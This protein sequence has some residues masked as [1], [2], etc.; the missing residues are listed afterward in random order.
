MK[1]NELV[2]SARGHDRQESKI[3]DKSANPLYGAIAWAGISAGT[4]LMVLTLP[5]HESQSVY[6]D[7]NSEFSP[8][9]ERM[10]GDSPDKL[11]SQ[12]V[13]EED[14]AKFLARTK[15]NIVPQA[16][17]TT[18]EVQRPSESASSEIVSG[19]ATY[20][21]VDDGY[22][23]QNRLGCTHEP[24]DPDDPTTAAR[25]ETSPFVCGD[26]LEVCDVNSC[27]EVEIKDTC[28]GCDDYGIVIDLSY[29]AMEDLA[30]K[31]GTTVVT[32]RKK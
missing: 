28:P 6:Q 26:K 30:G 15:L 27:I 13:E 12:M 5:R 24:F 3:E 21:G 10:T 17:Q 16:V 29:G 32:I 1:E 8:R 9:A 31:H 11:L 18:E 2:I 22:G 23:L 25:S 14:P 19:K 4:I 20:Y 7:E